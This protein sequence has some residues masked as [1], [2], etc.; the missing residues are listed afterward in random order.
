VNDR[1]IQEFIDHAATLPQG[2]RVHALVSMVAERCAAIC[3][4]LQDDRQCKRPAEAAAETIRAA[5]VAEAPRL[6][7]VAE[8]SRTALQ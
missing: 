5:F 2:H 7:K 4:I 1:L 6:S 8:A 3:D